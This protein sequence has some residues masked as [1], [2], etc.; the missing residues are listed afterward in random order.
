V[1]DERLK[2]ATLPQ[3]SPSRRLWTPFS[4][5]LHLAEDKP[6]RDLPP[7]T[8]LLNRRQQLWLPMYVY[9]YVCACVRVCMYVCVCVCMYACVYYVCMYACTHVRTYVCIIFMYV[10]IPVCCTSQVCLLYLHK[11]VCLNQCAKTN[12]SVIRTMGV[13][14]S[15]S[16]HCGIWANIVLSAF[17]CCAA[18]HSAGVSSATLCQD[19]NWF[20]RARTW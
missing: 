4:R 7:L 12:V 1:S 19:L 11:H 20:R 5:A 3:L 9:V 16:I 17:C 2:P 18:R 15:M 13:S 14:R 10:C 6:S 8:E